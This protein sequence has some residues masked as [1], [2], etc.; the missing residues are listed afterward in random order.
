MIHQ[1][2]LWP[3][4][5]N[6]VVTGEKTFELRKDD[7]PQKFHPQDILVLKEFDP[8]I[9][10]FTGREVTKVVTYL[11]RDAPQFGLQ[12]GYCIMG[13]GNPPLTELENEIFRYTYTQSFKNIIEDID[14]VG[15]AHE[16]G[17]FTEE[18]FINLLAR[19]ESRIKQ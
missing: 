11:L 13:L 18:D 5:Y 6:R 1:L 7:R 16:K 12:P 4:Y 15:D 10:D 3:E 9:K 17:E 8:D 2:K 14:I 19:W